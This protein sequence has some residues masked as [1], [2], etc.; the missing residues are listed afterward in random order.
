MDSVSLSRKWNK[1]TAWS[2]GQCLDDCFLMIMW[3][4]PPLNKNPH[5][6]D[7]SQ[8]QCRGCCVSHLH[9][10]GVCYWQILKKLTTILFFPGE[11]DEISRKD[12]R[13]TLARSKSLSAEFETCLDTTYTH[14][15]N[16]ESES[17]KDLLNQR[18]NKYFQTGNMF[19]SRIGLSKSNFILHSS[20]W[21]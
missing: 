7:V 3:T 13:F 19:F 2:A 14:T 6:V 5:K 15:L 9:Y 16:I 20:C 12:Q 1:M 17:D 8:F 4:S 10:V 18:H 21:Q 11:P